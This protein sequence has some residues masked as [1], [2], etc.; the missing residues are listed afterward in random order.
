MTQTHAKKED[1]KKIRKLHRVGE[2]LLVVVHS[3]IVKEAGLDEGVF[4]EQELGPDGIIHMKPLQLEEKSRASHGPTT[5]PL[6][7]EADNNG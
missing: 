4:F 5:K 2:S 7:Q 1:A 6:S 3:D